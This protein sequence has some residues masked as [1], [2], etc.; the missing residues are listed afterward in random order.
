MIGKEEEVELPELNKIL[1]KYMTIY[2]K[3]SS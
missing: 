1:T 3:R 2:N